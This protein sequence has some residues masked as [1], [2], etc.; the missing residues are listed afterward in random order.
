RG[1]DLREGQDA[2]MDLGAAAGADRVDLP[3]VRILED[4]LLLVVAAAHHRLVDVAGGDAALAIDL[5]VSLGDAMT[6]DAG[7][8]FARDLATLP[9]R[10]LAC[11]AALRADLLVAAHA[12][13]ADRARG[14]VIDAL[15]ELVEDRRDRGIGVV[16]GR[17]FLEDLL[18]TLLADAGAG[19][20]VL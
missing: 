3:V 20:G 2:G 16:R 19:I 15:L 14:E 7:D 6:G 4:D 5:A 9:E 8:A 12:E 10:L 13:C 17:P 1:V 11:L 18:V